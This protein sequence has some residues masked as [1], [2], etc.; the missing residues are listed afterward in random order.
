MARDA[1][2]IVMVVGAVG[3]LLIFGYAAHKYGEAMRQ[4]RE[5]AGEGESPM[6]GVTVSAGEL[7]LLGFVS[8]VLCV[9]LF[10]FSGVA[11]LVALLLPT[12]ILVWVRSR[13]ARASAPRSAEVTEEWRRLPVGYRVYMVLAFF[14]GPVGLVLVLSGHPMPGFVLVGLWLLDM[15]IIRPV[16]LARNR[17]KP[18]AKSSPT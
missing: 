12:A 3:M 13:R 16:L 14:P 4:E 18:W 5:A 2:Q 9:A 11:A 15:A 17:D 8:V 10:E 7:L 1:L 6:R